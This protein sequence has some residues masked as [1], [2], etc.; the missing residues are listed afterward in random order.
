MD[1]EE[2]EWEKHPWR[3]SGEEHQLQ[4]ALIS[5]IE[6]LMSVVAGE[7]HPVKQQMAG[8]G[9]LG[10]LRAGQDASQE[11]EQRPQHPWRQVQFEGRRGQERQGCQAGQ[12]G[13]GARASSASAGQTGCQGKASHP[14]LAR[15]HLGL[16]HG[17]RPAQQHR[18]LRACLGLGFGAS[19]CFVAD[20]PAGAKCM[21][22][23]VWKSPTGTLKVPVERDGDIV[24]EAFDRG[25]HHGGRAAT[26][27]HAG[28][29]DGKEGAAGDGH[30]DP[31][32]DHG[33]GLRDQRSL[34]TGHLSTEGGDP[35]VGPG[36]GQ[37]GQ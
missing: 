13:S 14:G 32:R 10:V 22:R 17:V 33:Q 7:N 29:Q 28:G 35:E 9:L 15:Q 31:A 6:L 25:L 16:W 27:F 19:R 36:G 8:I 3:R 23:L 24:V 34:G 5:I 20:A 11:E 37:G 2:C 21:A 30:D 18:W 26:F 4:Q 1:F 12:A